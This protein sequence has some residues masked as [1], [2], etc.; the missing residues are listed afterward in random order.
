V[1]AWVLIDRAETPD[2]GALELW[3]R[4]DEFSI[5]SAGREL[6]GSAQ[7]GSEQRLAALALAAVDRAA[8]DRAALGRAALGRAARPRVL[9]GGLGFGY[10]LAAA[11]AG[12]GSTGRV[13]VAEISAAVIAWNRGAPGEL[14]GQPLRDPRVLL[15]AADVIDELMH[16]EE[17]FEVILLDVDN[18]PSAL[19]QA[20][21]AWLYD[22]RGLAR[23]NAALSPGG[24]LGVWS[25]GPDPRF[26][27]R[28]R[29]QRFRVD[30]H[31]V[32]A[33]GT[34]GKRHIIWIA[35]RGS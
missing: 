31:R 18:G 16:A 27:K 17:P 4:G 13:V 15:R 1:R 33:S 35:K 10:T 19:S 30:E 20:R 32:H 9:I 14:A 22:E 34:R 12:L 28:L 6:M 26:V 11:L 2:G 23:L 24:V 29:A 21:N 8:V 7:H 5:R 3:Q 25:A